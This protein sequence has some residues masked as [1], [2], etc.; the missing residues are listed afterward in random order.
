MKTDTKARIEHTHLGG[1]QHNKSN[2][3]HTH[4]HRERERERNLISHVLSN[5]G[6]LLRYTFLPIP[7]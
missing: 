6:M 4:I 7:I 1:E 2:K 5:D 3:T